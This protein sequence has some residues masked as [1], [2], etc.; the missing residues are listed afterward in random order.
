MNGELAVK[1]KCAA[2][3]P[4]SF[5]APPFFL[6]G[7]V[8]GLLHNLH[9]PAANMCLWD[10][11][12]VL[13]PVQQDTL[14]D[15]PYFFPILHVQSHLSD[16]TQHTFQF[17][18]VEMSYYCYSNEL[19]SLWCKLILGKQGIID[20]TIPADYPKTSDK[21]DRIQCKESN[22]VYSR[23]IPVVY[24][25]ELD[26]WRSHV[27]PI[28]WRSWAWYFSR[29]YSNSLDPF[30]RRQFSRNLFTAI[31]FVPIR[32]RQFFVKSTLAY[33][34]MRAGTQAVR[35]SA[36]LGGALT[37]PLCC[38]VRTTNRWSGHKQCLLIK[39]TLF[40]HAVYIRHLA[41]TSRH[42]LSKSRA[43]EC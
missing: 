23:Y 3:S 37:P 26:I 21:L 34:S 35:W 41:Q 32:R 12:N 8:M 22:T 11:M 28:F 9:D 27:G 19:W 16:R 1:K 43:C 17:I 29:N 4:R 15:S 38:R 36:M 39:S 24:I 33:L 30:C 6:H 7:N 25:V 20:S 10:V 18:R 40:D 13:V 14:T 31:A 42:L 2:N 5:A